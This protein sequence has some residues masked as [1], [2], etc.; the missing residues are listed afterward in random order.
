MVSAPARVG[1]DVSEER[2]RSYCGGFGGGGVGEVRRGLIGPQLRP[3]LQ[4]Q[5]LAW[6]WGSSQQTSSGDVGAGS[7]DGD[8][9]TVGAGSV[10]L[11][12][13]TSTPPIPMSA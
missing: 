6:G 1:W 11:V 12:G 8:G 5:S 9:S 7:T 3:I 2:G 13:G 10:K 4:C